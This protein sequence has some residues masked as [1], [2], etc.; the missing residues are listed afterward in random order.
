MTYVTKDPAIQLAGTVIEAQSFP[1]LTIYFLPNHVVR[2]AHSVASI[3]SSGGYR[4][5]AH[6][7][8]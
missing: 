3:G 6:P 7:P 1:V 5:K 4:F 2:Q 8:L